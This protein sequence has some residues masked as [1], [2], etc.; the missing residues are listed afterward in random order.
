MYGFNFYQWNFATLSHSL[1]YVMLSDELFYFLAIYL[2]SGMTSCSA[3]KDFNSLS[4]Q[5]A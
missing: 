4:S 2:A 1:Q 5:G 3:I